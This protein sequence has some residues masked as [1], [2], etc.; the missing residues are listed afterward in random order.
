MFFYSLLAL[1][2]SAKY[3][4]RTKLRCHQEL[5]CSNNISIYDV[6]NKE[7]LKGFDFKM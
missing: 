2:Y 3:M 7:F 6:S 4:N 5:P 1:F